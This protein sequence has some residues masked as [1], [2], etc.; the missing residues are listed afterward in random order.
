MFL[1]WLAAAAGG[2]IE[3]RKLITGSGRLCGAAVDW[4]PGL[5]WQHPQSFNRQAQPQ[6]CKVFSVYCSVKLE[7]AKSAIVLLKSAVPSASSFWL[8]EK[9]L[10]MNLIKLTLVIHALCMCRWAGQ[11]ACCF[12]L[13]GSYE[14]QSMLRWH[15]SWRRFTPCCHTARRPYLPMPS[16]SLRNWT[17][18]R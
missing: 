9:A 6:W 2:E 3:H 10:I 18:A 8:P 16:S 13:R 15:L 14:R 7:S 17:S 5:P 4:S 11:R 1:V 12:R